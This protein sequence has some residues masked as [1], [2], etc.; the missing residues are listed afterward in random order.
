M[1]S[2]LIV[3]LSLFLLTSCEDDYSY[4]TK[5]KK[6]EYLMGRND[7][8]E[9]KGWSPNYG[10]SG[11]YVRN[12]NFTTYYSLLD[13]IS[14][15]QTRMFPSLT[16]KLSYDVSDSASVT[17]YLNDQA[18]KAKEISKQFLEEYDLWTSEYTI[19]SE[20][21]LKNGDIL[22]AEMIVGNKKFND[23]IVAIESPIYSDVL[24]VKFGDTKEA[25]IAS[26][27]ERY[28]SHS[29]SGGIYNAFYFY[30][31]SS[32]SLQY[33]YSSHLYFKDDNRYRSTITQYDFENNKLSSV[34][35]YYKITE[36][37]LS[38][39]LAIQRLN[40][41]SRKHGLTEEIVLSENG[42][43]TKEYKWSKNGLQFEIV[44]DK[45]P[46]G[47]VQLAGIKYSKKV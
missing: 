44:L 1:K 40:T 12:F 21:R 39:N 37:T 15:F 11:E 9:K 7:L 45:D 19:N 2:I 16:L 41:Y 25:V 20:T 14:S 13:T 10:Y 36:E 17:T 38:I 42:N 6:E 24:G 34:T 23:V 27:K 31:R 46:E 28:I 8:L 30:E 29:A 32:S 47:Q 33:N 5:K 3:F 4:I 18:I 35:E 43:L 22:R 26:E